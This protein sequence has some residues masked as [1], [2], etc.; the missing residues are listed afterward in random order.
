MYLLYKIYNFCQYIIEYIAHNVP[1]FGDVLSAEQAK[2]K[3][4]HSTR[5]WGHATAAA[6]KIPSL[7]KGHCL[8]KLTG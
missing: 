4:I 3:A 2:I 8:L 6:A 5:F 1:A 7:M